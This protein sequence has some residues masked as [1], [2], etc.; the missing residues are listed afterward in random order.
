MNINLINNNKEEEEFS[1]NEIQTI[2]EI[3]LNYKCLECEEKCPIYKLQSINDVTK[4]FGFLKSLSNEDF[5]NFIRYLNFCIIKQNK[6]FPPVIYSQLFK[7]LY[8]NVRCPRCIGEECEHRVLSGI[9]FKVLTQY[10]YSN[11]ELQRFK[12]IME[13]RIEENKEFFC[14]N[15]RVNI[16]KL[17]IEGISIIE[18]ISKRLKGISNNH[19]STIMGLIKASNE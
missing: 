16:L 13:K 15:E 10:H 14:D 17:K 6:Q 5:Q 4:I 11:D 7:C 19:N 1:D 9:V 8:G 18:H 12:E 3:I 2:C